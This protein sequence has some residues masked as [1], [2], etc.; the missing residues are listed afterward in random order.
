MSE[1]TFGADRRG[2]STPVV[3]ALTLGI[4]AILVI[5]LVGTAS[6]FLADQEEFAARDQ[7]DSVGNSLAGQAEQ[8][9]AMADEN[10]EASFFVTQPARVVGSTYD[11]RLSSG[12]ACDTSRFSSDTCLV[13]EVP[14]KDMTSKTPVRV[15]DG[16]SLSLDRT[17]NTQFRVT[18]TATGGGTAA[19]GAPAA[20]ADRA[21]GNLKVGVGRDIE[22]NTYGR[23][24]D[25]TN[26]PPI[27]RFSFSPDYPTTNTLVRADADRS[28]DPDGSIKSYTWYVDGTETSPGGTPSTIETSLS[29]GA[30]NVTLVLTDDEGATARQSRTVRV[31]GLEYNKDMS[32]SSGTGRTGGNCA[33]FSITN[34]WGQGI[35]VSHLSID[36]PDKVNFIDY[37][38]GA[39]IAIDTNNDGDYTDAYDIRYDTGTIDVRN[40]P[41]GVVL[42]LGRGP[43]RLDISAGQTVGVSVCKFKGGGPLRGQNDFPEFGFRYWIDGTTNRTVFGAEDGP[44]VTDYAV[45]RSGGDVT[46]SFESS[47][48]LDTT[49]FGGEIGSGG[50]T[51]TV[52]G[53]DFS[54]GVAGGT[55]TYEATFSRPS[56]TYYVRLDDAET[57]DGT[58]VANLPQNASAGG[59]SATGPYVWQTGGDWDSA[60]R[61]VGVVH[62][63]YGDYEAGSLRLGTPPGS[64]DGSLVSYWPF[65]G[66]SVA[67][68]VGGND[69]TITGSPAT[70]DGIAG[71]TA[72]SFD[73]SDDHLTVPDDSSLEMSD[74]EVT[75]SMWVNKDSRQGGYI[76]LFE[77]GYAYNMLFGGGNDFI[78]AINDGGTL[79]GTAPE[80]I[81]H[82]ADRYY[83][84][85]GT[86][87]GE[88][89]RSYVD[90]TR[91]GIDS[92]PDEMESASGE[93]AGIATDLATDARYLDGAIDDIRVYD[94]R[95]TD[96]QVEQLSNVTEGYVE[97]ASKTGDAVNMKKLDLSYDADI[98]S[99]ESIELTV[100][101]PGRESDTITLGASD[102]GTE[103]VDVSGFR[104]GK[105]SELWVEVRLT[106]SSPATSPELDGVTLEEGS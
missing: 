86:F 16:V 75:V 26:R 103:T 104:G 46:V 41:D 82:R 88:V 32:V 9:G 22:R 52:S 40:K 42:T 84:L 74:D 25:P 10:G 60:D 63:G 44:T 45:T 57:A 102:S 33:E 91:V 59:I 73:G 43:D 83:H 68:L 85:V 65:D 79:Y 28:R 93:D 55:Y 20:E 5:L 21:S 3:H 96:E 37:S 69:G 48:E 8:A 12:P 99:G 61:S 34:Q 11:V 92:R 54:E 90:G 77:K 39:E 18:A 80:G 24:V 58:E 1:L 30:H 94:D 14:D 23:V 67:D 36:P 101:A 100:R 56:G 72:L 31:S 71:T 27:P 47:E 6:T 66:G 29:A 97:T 51:T 76:W 95:L 105:E 50:S 35:D 17:G 81:D 89:M 64:V 98:D 15:R 70:T 78:F 13:V 38:S 53:S 7:L 106:S 62:D 49:T 87:D 4:T 2:V 19:T